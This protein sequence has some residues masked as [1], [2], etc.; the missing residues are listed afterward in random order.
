VDGAAPSWTTPPQSS[1]I[2]RADVST[3]TAR[4]SSC[5]DGTLKHDDSQPSLETARVY[6]VVFIDAINVKIRALSPIL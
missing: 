5:N 1:T 4:A 2:G 6:P 3:T